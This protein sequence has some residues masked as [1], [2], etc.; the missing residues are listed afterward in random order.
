MERASAERWMREAL[1]EAQRAET[2][3]EVPVGAIILINEKIVGRGH[4][5]SIRSH[6]PTAHAEVLALRH[7]AH[8]MRNYR[9]PGSI[10]VVT[11]EPCLMCVGALIHARVDEIVFGAADPR[12]GAVQ[13]VFQMANVPQLNHQI[14]VTSGVLADECGGLLRAFFESRR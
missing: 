7:A 13:S 1:E 4:N 5:H 8:S 11:I 10:L 3:G 2:E 9:L 12:A 14:A 6:D